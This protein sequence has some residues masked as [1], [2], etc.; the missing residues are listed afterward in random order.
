[1]LSSSKRTTSSHARPISSAVSPRMRA[2]LFAPASNNT[3]MTAGCSQIAADASGVFSSFDLASTSALC[4]INSEATSSCPHRH[5]SSRAVSPSP[6]RVSVLAPC[7]SKDC[8]TW[9]S[10]L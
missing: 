1:M 7:A 6:L 2:C 10:P 3:L 9:R 4:R 8:T 5:V